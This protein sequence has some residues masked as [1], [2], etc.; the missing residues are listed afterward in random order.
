MIA[1]LDRKRATCRPK[2]DKT[3]VHLR[4]IMGHVFVRTPVDL[5]RF[6]GRCQHCVGRILIPG[7]N[8]LATVRPDIAA[9]WHPT[10]NGDLTPNMVKPGSQIEVWWQCE[11]GHAFPGRVDYRCDQKK[12]TCPVDTGRLLLTGVN[13]LATREPALVKDWDYERNG[14]G[15]SEVVPGAKPH[16]WICKYGHTQQA[17]P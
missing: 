8:D 13:D 17:A 2:T 12:R 4:C 14:F 16:A 1:Y 3:K 11:D 6:R 7:V 10:H 9:W 5:V 15:P